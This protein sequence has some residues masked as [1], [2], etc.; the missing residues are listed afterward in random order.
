MFGVLHGHG[1]LGE[2]FVL[3]KP[4]DDIGALHG[5]SRGT[6]R[7]VVDDACRYQHTRSSYEFEAYVGVVRANYTRGLGLDA[8]GQYMHKRAL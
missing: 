5:L 6:F 4:A 1:L 7:Q 8:L 3:A 2:S